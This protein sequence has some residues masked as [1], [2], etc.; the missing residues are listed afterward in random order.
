MSH[1]MQHSR[2][3]RETLDSH[4]RGAVTRGE[5]VCEYECVCRGGSLHKAVPSLIHL[6]LMAKQH[7][8]CSR[9]ATALTENA[10]GNK[11]RLV[12]VGRCATS[13]SDN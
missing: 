2:T 12:P 3:T 4:V 11:R 5:R 9:G 10:S 8:D 7:G 1:V 13:V 6:T